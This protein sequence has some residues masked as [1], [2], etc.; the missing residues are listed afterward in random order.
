[1][2]LQVWVIRPGF[3]RCPVSC[4]L[5]LCTRAP[6]ST[7]R[8]EEL[9][10]KH[11][12]ND[13]KR[14]PGLSPLDPCRTRWQE[15]CGTGPADPGKP[16]RS[17]YLSY[18]VVLFPSRR[19]DVTGTPIPC[20][21]AFLPRV[22][23]EQYPFCTAPS[24]GYPSGCKGMGGHGSSS[25]SDGI[26]PGKISWYAAQNHYSSPISRNLAQLHNA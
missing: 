17:H 15:R 18:V 10:Q 23:D 5:N 9:T 2:Y 4:P 8:V 21:I 25:F 16:S 24:P 14:S 11:Q 1:M 20:P 3:L 22:H 6:D 7:L 13:A 19:N 12:G 26:Q